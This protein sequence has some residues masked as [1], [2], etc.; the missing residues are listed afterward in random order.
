MVDRRLTLFERLKSRFGFA[1]PLAGIIGPQQPYGITPLN[2]KQPIGTF[3]TESFSGYSQEEYLS[4]L[5]GRQ[6]AR[7]YDQMRRSDP[8]I[9]MCLTAIKNPITGATWEVEP[10]DDSDD[11][12]ADAELIEHILFND[13]DSGFNQFLSEAVTM[14]EFGHSVFEVIHKVSQSPQYGTFNSL[15][16]LAFRSQKT[17]ER[18]N[19]VPQTGALLSI[20]Q[21][22][23]G[24]I[25]KVVD[26][27]SQFLMVYSINREGANYEGI[28]LLRHCYGPWFRK[29]N[30]LKLNAIGIEKFA[31]PTPTVEIPPGKQYGPEYD[32]MSENLESYLTH[33]K[34]YL[35]YPSGWKVTLNN[36][37]YDPAKVETSID[38]EDRRMTKSFL[39][40]FLE[41]GMQGTGGSYSLG[42][43]LSSFFL[44]GLDH[45]A[46]KIAEPINKTIIPNLIKMNRG[47]RSGYPMLKHSG[48]SDKAGKELSE[49]MKN[50][51]DGQVIIPD[52]RLEEHIRKRHG[53]PKASTDGR[54]VPAVSNSQIA[55]TPPPASSQLAERI[56]MAELRNKKRLGELI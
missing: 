20:S 24:D 31:V 44:D 39:E 23:Y 35:L 46:L 32:A 7:V 2:L 13:M 37:V 25:G 6:R 49:L 10:F 54:R 3:G 56:R 17:I 47:N 9:V 55:S 53:L 12:K 8:Q 42:N 34:N 4:T 51:T 43:N 15:Q 1:D 19:L 21:Y 38:S 27:P 5:R 22:A 18:W 48:I 52:D 45:I 40:N 28:S 29:N 16:A 26:I 33:E 14:V 41:L 11:A 50:Y 30:Y 36:N